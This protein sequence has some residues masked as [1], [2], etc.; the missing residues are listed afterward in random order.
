MKRMYKIFYWVILGTAGLLLLA[1]CGPATTS[2]AEPAVSNVEEALAEGGEETT[3]T[4][5]AVTDHDY[6]N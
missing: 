6:T 4:D 2:D 1:A 3:A 5:T